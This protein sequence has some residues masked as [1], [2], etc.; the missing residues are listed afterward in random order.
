MP[1]RETERARDRG[2]PLWSRNKGCF[3][4][5]FAG[6]CLT[7]VSPGNPP[8][9]RFVVF[10]TSQHVNIPTMANSDATLDIE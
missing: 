5:L 1:G 6:K 3:M 8:K 9:S 7:I 10:V 4:Q 2:V